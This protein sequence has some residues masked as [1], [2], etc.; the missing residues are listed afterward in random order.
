[1]TLDG[2]FALL[3]SAPGAHPVEPDRLRVVA[4]ARGV[5]PCANSPLLHGQYIRLSATQVFV[6]LWT[7]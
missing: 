5:A 7:N 6:V 1:M 3:K 2:S 4:D